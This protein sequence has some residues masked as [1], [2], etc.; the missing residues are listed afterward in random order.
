M[1][2]TDSKEQ[3]EAM[4]ALQQRMQN[5]RAGV[6][7]AATQQWFL[8]DRKLNVGE[9]ADKL[10]RMMQWRQDFLR[11]VTPSA[12]DVA[13]E[14]ATGKAYLHSHKDVN[15]R[16]VIVIRASR[17]ITGERPLDDSKRLCAH[18]LEKAVD[19]LDDG[20]ETIL[21]IFDLRGF[22]TQ[23][24]DFGFVRFLVDVFFSYYPKRL[25][26]VL[27]VDAPWGFNA[28]WSVVKPWLKKYAAL[29]SFVSRE[30]LRRQYFTPETC[31]EDFKR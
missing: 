11:G 12:A 25:G 9:A 14:A 17:H 18:L 13:A 27:M 10:V 30:E 6:P 29:V 15:G 20:G 5:C 31:P 26:Q 7:D 22:G 8:R 24:A 2:W 3:K 19:E 28:G 21:G 4:Q 23:N 1:P 16:P